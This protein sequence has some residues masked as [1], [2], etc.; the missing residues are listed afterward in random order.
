MSN[1][2]PAVLQLRSSAGMYGAEHMLLTLQRNLAGCGV[3]SRL[4]AIDNYLLDDQPLHDRAA[5]AGL[6]VARLPCR[7]RI[8]ARTVLALLE[9]IDATGAGVLH[10]HDYKS[11]FYAWMAARRRPVQL[12]ATLHGW[13]ETS[14]ALRLYTRLELAL[15]RR[16][17][18]LVVVS[19]TQRARLLRSGVPAARIH[20]I[21]N[22]ID[23]DVDVANHR[24]G[25][26]DRD[27]VLADAACVVP[28]QGAALRAELGLPA[29]GR[30]LAA[31][32]R[33]APEKNL[34]QLIDAFARH[35]AAHPD[36]SLLLVGEGPER[37]ALAERVSAAGLQGRIVLAGARQD[38][39]AVYGLI[40]TLVLPSLGE[41][42][43]LVVLEAMARGIPVIASAVGEVPRLLAD[44]AHGQLVQPGDAAA[45]A[46][47]IHLTLQSPPLRDARAARFVHQHHG[48]AAMAARY[49]ALYAAL[50]QPGLDHA[51]A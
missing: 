46:A 29:T 17:D 23:V 45:L 36:A 10:A 13:V 18:A 43:P 4:L 30:V 34:G 33:L 44:S 48:G 20:C 50:R 21:D 28:G 24:A 1:G 9:Q 3:R 15:L 40:D 42:M 37:L 47:A 6:D 14:R 32:G 19:E 27:G 16:F 39:S 22:G 5:A 41:G 38:M 2:A 8:D 51:A 35:A 49:A 26:C 11:A 7:G 25:G 31:V 12:V